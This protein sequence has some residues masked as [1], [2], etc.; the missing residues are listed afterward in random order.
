M[1]FYAVQLLG[2]VGVATSVV[3]RSSTDVVRPPELG[4]VSVMEFVEVPTF[5]WQDPKC[6]YYGV[7][8][9]FARTWR[10]KV[11]STTFAI[12]TD[13]YREPEPGKI[14]AYAIL[15][16]KRVCKDK[17]EPEYVELYKVSYALRGDYPKGIPYVFHGLPDANSDLRPQWLPQVVE[18][19]RKASAINPD[20][21]ALV[22]FET[23][24]Y[25]TLKAA[26]M[27]NALQGA[28]EPADEES[29]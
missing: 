4:Q 15:V 10:E 21:K 12:D 22:D 18:A 20:V 23:Q 24:Y 17:P 25:K 16:N 19:I 14:A 3:V 11:T 2:G 29:K 7:V 9:P 28:P 26:Q 6:T 8:T 27:D 5:R 13:T 1:L